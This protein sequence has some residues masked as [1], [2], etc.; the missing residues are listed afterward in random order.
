[1]N[2]KLIIKE[3][4][5]KNFQPIYFLHGEEPYYIDAISDAVLDH[6]LEDHERG[7]N[8]SIIY[9]KSA[10][11]QMLINELKSF[12]MGSE[13]RLVVLKEAQYFNKIE[14]LCT[15]LENPNPSTVFVLC[16]K[17]KKYDLRKKSLKLS[18]KNGLVFH[19]QKVKEY[20]LN[21]WIE[22]HIRSVGYTIKS[23]GIMLLAESLGNDLGRIVNE[24]KKLGIIIKKGEQIT[25][26]VIEENIGVSKDYNVYELTNAVGAL[27][28]DKSYI[29]INYF[30]LNPKAAKLHQVVS[31]LFTFF[32]QILKIHFIKQNSREAIAKTLRVH[33]FV[34]GELTKAKNRFS[35]KKIASNI[36]ILQEFDLKSKGYGNASSE[37]ADLMKELVFKLVNP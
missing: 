33:P 5:N 4:K 25:E 27:D 13:K 7:F 23:K 21:E 16:Y 17:H 34:A 24:I 14:E 12:P 35:P 3:I 28:L 30:E 31:S 10:E 2:H 36:E 22:N 37:D 8:Q 9:G 20:Q 15:Y 29:I 32:S 19:S 6:C 1:M 26:Q 18:S 11:P